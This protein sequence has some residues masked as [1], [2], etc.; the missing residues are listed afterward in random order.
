MENVCEKSMAVRKEELKT[1]LLQSSRVLKFKTS[2]YE[3]D[4]AGNQVILWD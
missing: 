4:L 1:V 2:E 3:D